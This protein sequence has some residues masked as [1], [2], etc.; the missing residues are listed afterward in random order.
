MKKQIQ[1]FFIFSVITGAHSL[2]GV[3]KS[4]TF[5]A[6]STNMALTALKTRLAALQ[7]VLKKQ[8]IP[9]AAQLTGFAALLYVGFMTSVNCKEPLDWLKATP[10]SQASLADIESIEELKKQA[11]YRLLNNAIIY[12]MIAYCG[13]KL[14]KMQK[15]SV[16]GEADQKKAGK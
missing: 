3:A 4:G 13:V 7:V 10:S 8:V 16:P 1:L 9:L 14:A 5:S 12:A 15:T 2:Y 11:R 6:E